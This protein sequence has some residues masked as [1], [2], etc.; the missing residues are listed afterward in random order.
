MSVTRAQIQEGNVKG[1]LATLERV[2][3][4]APEALNVRLLY[5]IILYRLD[6]MAGAEREFQTVAETDLPDDVRQQVNT[7]LA[8]IQQQQQA[9]KQSVRVSVGGTGF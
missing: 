2:L 9:T 8:D 3:L 5:A 4:I 1:A 7:Y 6:N